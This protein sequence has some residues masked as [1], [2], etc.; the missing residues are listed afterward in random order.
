MQPVAEQNDDTK[1]IYD[2]IAEQYVEF[3]KAPFWT[4]IEEYTSFDV[5]LLPNESGQTDRDDGIR[6]LDLACGDGHY[7][8]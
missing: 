7:T 5:I 3:K 4:A 6:I 2:S 1:K 8:R